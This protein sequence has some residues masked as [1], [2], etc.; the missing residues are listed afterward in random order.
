MPN[1][2]DTL[3]GI[4]SYAARGLEGLHEL[5]AE[6]RAA[7]SCRGE[8]LDWWVVAGYFVLDECGNTLV[9][10][11][12]R[13]TYETFNATVPEVFNR[14]YLKHHSRMDRSMTITSRPI[15]SPKDICP[16]CLDGW[17]LQTAWDCSWAAAK[18]LPGALYH[19]E[20]ARLLAIS[21]ETEWF[22]DLLDNSINYER[23]VAIPNRYSRTSP[24]PWFTVH[25][26]CGP[27]QIGCRKNVISI[28]W[29]KAEHLRHVDGCVLFKDEGV[30]VSTYLVHAWGREK[31]IEYLKR[32]MP[33]VLDQIE[34]ATS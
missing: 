29:D 34:I 21:S 33:G 11:D 22:K 25:T 15:Q 14:A 28:Q 24:R 32:L 16:Q 19:E 30:T 5:S 13:P 20:C 1:K 9:I 2:Y 31:A 27:I 6:R 17:T 12:G 8:Q 4:K 26:V 23:M 10:S 3:D 7:Y 18:S